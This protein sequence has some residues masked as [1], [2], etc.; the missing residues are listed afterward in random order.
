MGQTAVYLRVSTKE[1]N[2]STQRQPITDYCTRNNLQIFREYADEG[3]SGSTISR[4]MLDLLLKDMRS[5]KFNT[6]IVYRLDRL[7]RSL[8]HLLQIFEE[9]RNKKIQ[10]ISI[11]DNINTADESP[12][13]RAFWS[14][15]GVFSELERSIIVERVKAGLARARREGKQLGRRAGSKDKN[16]RSVSGY[17]LRYAGR[18]KDERRLGKRKIKDVSKNLSVA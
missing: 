18:S 4:P 12:T 8:G 6:I 5:G 15:L 7:G 13:A 14:L 9:L 1:Q 17:C 16:K 2:I 3:I 10:L 11:S